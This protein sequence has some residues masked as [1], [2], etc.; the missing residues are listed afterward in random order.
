L[1]N[2][3][4]A[5]KT[6]IFVA[7]LIFDAISIGVRANLRE[8]QRPFTMRLYKIVNE[9]QQKINSFAHSIQLLTSFPFSRDFSTIRVEISRASRKEAP[10]NGAC[11]LRIHTR[12]LLYG[13]PA[14][15]I[16]TNTVSAQERGEL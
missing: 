10:L 11:S 1:L 7:I 8:K 5:Q 6:L 12:A 4:T 16:R 2:L 14:L 9:N 15:Q 13:E 3:I